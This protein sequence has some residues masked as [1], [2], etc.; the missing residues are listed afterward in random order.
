MDSM[1]D[2]SEERLGDGVPQKKRSLTS[3]SLGWLAEKLRKCERIKSELNS[4]T[5]KVDSAA[6]AQS[7]TN[8][9]ED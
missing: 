1:S 8:A 6:I 4:G 7:I 9:D 5:Y 2:N 3:I